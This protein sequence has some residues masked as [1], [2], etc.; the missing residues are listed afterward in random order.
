M[1]RSDRKGQIPSSISRGNRFHH[2]SDFSNILGKRKSEWDSNK[3]R[4]SQASAKR[5]A[6][7]PSWEEARRNEEI[8]AGAESESESTSSSLDS[9]GPEHVEYGRRAKLE[10]SP[11]GHRQ[12]SYFT[13]LADY[14][15][16]LC[17]Y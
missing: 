4:Y 6:T 3:D 7:T 17:L 16:E 2:R 5:H 13:Y 11:I 15:S 8:D 14:G 12:I 9:D 1:S 10:G